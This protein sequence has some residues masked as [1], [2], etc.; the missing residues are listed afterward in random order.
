MQGQTVSNLVFK[1]M[2]RPASIQD[3]TYVPYSMT[4]REMT[5]KI[6][7]VYTKTEVN[8][9]T[10]GYIL[11]ETHRVR[12]SS[13][14]TTTTFAQLINSLY[15]DAVTYINTLDND[16]YYQL[17]SVRVTGNDCKYVTNDIVRTTTLSSLE[18]NLYMMI[19]LGTTLF[20]YYIEVRSN[21]A[22]KV[23]KYN[24][25]GTLT[26]VSTN[27]IGY[28]KNIDFYFNLYHINDN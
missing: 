14:S 18:Q 24:S 6:S 19:K 5:A 15:N 28:A 7:N 3:D 25:D 11:I 16:T 20:M 23:F 8:A 21:N 17:A 1:P 12:V 26:E 27:V 13:N 9:L 22:S 4:N 10:N 2:L